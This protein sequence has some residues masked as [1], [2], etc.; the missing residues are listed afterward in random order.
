MASHLPIFTRWICRKHNCGS[1]NFNNLGRHEMP[2][3]DIVTEDTAG[4]IRPKTFGGYNGDVSRHYFKDWILYSRT[5]DMD[6]HA[7]KAWNNYVKK[8]QSVKVKKKLK[9]KNPFKGNNKRSRDINVPY[10]KSRMGSVV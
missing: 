6:R 1:Y 7:L 10:I 2:W 9:Y 3:C 4:I 8:H 5:E